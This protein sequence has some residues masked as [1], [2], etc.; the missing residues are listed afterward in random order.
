MSR[1]RAR[2]DTESFA[3]QD[4]DAKSTNSILEFMQLQGLS[5]TL[6]ADHSLLA[7][8][9][10]SLDTSSFLQVVAGA[11]DIKHRQSLSTLEKW[12]DRLT[13]L[14]TIANPCLHCN[15]EVALFLCANPTIV[16]DL[17]SCVLDL[18]VDVDGKEKKKPS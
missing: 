18:A 12:R 14:S 17:D 13:E 15:E 3:P 16:S 7:E 5:E 11:L 4:D 1:K 2:I 6:A 8:Y 9:A 10:K